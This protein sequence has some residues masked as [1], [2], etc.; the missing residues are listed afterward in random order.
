MTV[1]MRPRFATVQ[2]RKC[3]FHCSGLAIG[4]RFRR[5]PEPWHQQ[6]SPRKS[7]KV[8]TSL[9]ELKVAANHPAKGFV[10]SDDKQRLHCVLCTANAPPSADSSVEWK[11]Y[12]KHE[13][14][15]THK[16]AVARDALQ[17]KQVA[18][19]RRNQEADATRQ[20]D[21]ERQFA[22]LRDVNLP[23]KR[24]YRVQSTAE[25]DL[26]MQIDQDPHG[27]G[28]DAGISAAPHDTL[29]SLWNA[30]TMGLNS[31]FSLVPSNTGDSLDEDDTDEILAEIMRSAAFQGGTIVGRI[32][33]ILDDGIGPPIIILDVFQVSDER[34]EIFGMPVL[35]RRQSE[36]TYLII[37]T[38]DVKFLINA[39]HDCNAA[40]CSASGQRRR[41]QERVESDLFDTFIVHEPLERFIIN[42]HAFHNAHLLR[43]VLPRALTAPIALFVDRKEKHY[44]LATT[45]RETKDARRKHLK[46][47]KALKKKDTDAAKE[48]GGAG[49][50][51]T[52]KRKAKTAG[53]R[54]APA[55]RKAAPKAKK[56]NQ[57]DEESGDDSSESDS[58]PANSAESGDDGPPRKKRRRLEQSNVD[59]DSDYAAQAEE[60][61]AEGGAGNQDFEM[62]YKAGL[63]GGF[64]GWRPGGREVDDS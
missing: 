53:K 16:R 31:T 43:Q 18:E 63:S 34:H 58:D 28:F 32:D 62:W 1:F 8:R 38:I 11:N 15:E 49:P 26:W 14:S 56:S 51:K 23:E 17:Q 19:I 5:R 54:K 27:V 10:P 61:Q 29:L 64:L 33:D 12:R 35:T 9:P 48:A 2:I 59:S 46:E 39:Q 41:M 45:L 44:E 13:K 36:T 60:E 6:R 40:G 4:V 42:T 20:R 57:D 3:H 55:T 37:P 30:E 25:T 22:G 24:A 50:A 52:Q 7:L 21:A 47:K